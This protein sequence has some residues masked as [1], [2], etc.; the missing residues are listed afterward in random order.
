MRTLAVAEAAVA[1][2]QPV[3]RTTEH[4]AGGGASQPAGHTG[5]VENSSRRDDG[6]QPAG[7]ADLAGGKETSIVMVSP[8]SLGIAPVLAVLEGKI[9][10]RRVRAFQSISIWVEARESAA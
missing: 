4:V 5:T 9:D 3:C 7:Q 6:T 2:L 1:G 10:A 8:I